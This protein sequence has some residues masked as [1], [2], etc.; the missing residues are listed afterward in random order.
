MRQRL[1][2]IA[3]RA[4]QTT[5]VQCRQLSLD[6]MTRLKDEEVRENVVSG[7]TEARR[8]YHQAGDA[9]DELA[10]RLATTSATTVAG[11]FAKARVMRRAFAID[12]DKAFGEAFVDKLRE[13]MRTLGPDDEAFAMSLARDLIQLASKEDELAAI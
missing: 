2:F 13:R 12:D 11:A 1:A 3:A 9:Y 8:R 5:H 7:P 10:E 6:H 4:E